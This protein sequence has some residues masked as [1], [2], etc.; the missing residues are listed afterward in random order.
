MIKMSKINKIVCLLVIILWLSSCVPIIHTI[1]T[2]EFES[3]KLE[4]FSFQFDSHKWTA[5]FSVE[6]SNNNRHVVVLSSYDTVKKMNMFGGGSL[7]IMDRIRVFDLI[8]GI[9]PLS[10]KVILTDI[11]K[12]IK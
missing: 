7:L 3:V 1:F 11:I 9:V 5:A 4:Q 12:R 8:R 10:N 2:E 6:I